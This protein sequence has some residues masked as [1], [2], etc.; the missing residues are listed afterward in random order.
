M[1]RRA[2]ELSFLTIGVYLA[3]YYASGSGTVIN[4]AGQQGV[5]LVKAFQGR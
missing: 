3:V 2:L 4:S 1:I 5:N